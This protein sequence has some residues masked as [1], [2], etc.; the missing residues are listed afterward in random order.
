MQVAAADGRAAAVEVGAGAPEAA[1][2]QLQAADPLLQ[3]CGTRL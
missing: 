1:W 3:V 2:A